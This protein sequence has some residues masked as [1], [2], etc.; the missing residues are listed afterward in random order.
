MHRPEPSPKTFGEIVV[1]ERSSIVEKNAD[2]AGGG[3]VPEGEA[4]RIVKSLEGEAARGHTRDELSDEA[5]KRIAEMKR[6]DAEVRA[7]EQAHKRAGGSYAGLP[8]YDY[9]R[10]P[11]GRQ[12][13]VSG[14]VS[15]DTSS[16]NSPEATIR[17]MEIVMRAAMAPGDPS[18]QDRAVAT[19][20][21]RAI[22]EAQAELREQKAA[23]KDVSAQDQGSAL[24]SVIAGRAVSAYGRPV[25]VS[26]VTFVFN[27]IDDVG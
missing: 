27:R 23:E 8:Q 19:A 6:R 20:A 4:K 17:K 13:A 9:E 15:I 3:P 21:K 26:A 12:Y 16:E 2:V 1:R 18:A 24:N 10:G 14:E 7:H 11:D 5:K 22:E 25:A